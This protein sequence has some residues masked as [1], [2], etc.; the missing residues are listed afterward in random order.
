MQNQEVLEVWAEPRLRWPFTCG[1][2]GA[3]DSGKSSL[4]R[5]ILENPLFFCTEKFSKVLYVFNFYQKMFDDMKQTIPNIT[6]FPADQ[7]ETVIEE[8]KNIN[9]CLIV[10]DDTEH[11]L[12][13]REV[14][15]LFS[16]DVKHS[17]SSLIFIG[18]NLFPRERYGFDAMQNIFYKFIFPNC[19]DSS[20][21][22]TF[23]RRTAPNNKKKFLDTFYK[24]IMPRRRSPLLLDCHS[25]SPHEMMFRSGIRSCCQALY[26]FQK[27]F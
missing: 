8:K 11:L 17:N 25:D 10:L 2:F 22:A 13:R 19:R 5:D 24:D 4:V 21:I 16:G 23:A 26:T 18:H 14:Q 6:F 7:I 27:L 9:K 12:E 1:L 15:E 20:Q 3:S